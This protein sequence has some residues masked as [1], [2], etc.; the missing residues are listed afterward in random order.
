[1][2]KDENHSEDMESDESVKVPRQRVKS[3]ARGRK[4]DRE[5]SESIEDEPQVKRQRLEPP[6]FVLLYILSTFRSAQAKRKEIEECL[7]SISQGPKDLA[8]SNAIL[9]VTSELIDELTLELCFETHKKLK[10]GRLCQNCQRSRAVATVDDNEFD[11]FGNNMNN[12]QPPQ[13]VCQNGCN[14][15]VIASRYAPH[16]EQC[17]GVGKARVRRKEQPS[18]Y[19]TSY[20]DSGSEDNS[21]ADGTY[22]E[23]KQSSSRN[24]DMIIEK[25]E[26]K[27]RRKI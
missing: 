9:K 14:R 21:D 5:S 16:L 25:E 17:M 2:N 26:L 24:N 11:I 10:T 12:F 7:K 1:M 27:K 8:F 19:V 22:G 15:T 13:F 3:V 18:S 6:M 4:R 23:P 20:A